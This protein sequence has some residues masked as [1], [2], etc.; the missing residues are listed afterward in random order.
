MRRFPPSPG[1]Y[2]YHDGAVWLLLKGYVSNRKQ[3]LDI[4]FLEYLVNW[5]VEHWTRNFFDCKKKTTFLK[6]VV[7]NDVWWMLHKK[8]VLN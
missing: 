3:R 5:L 4:Q 2:V 1:V 8:K 6:N 7:Y